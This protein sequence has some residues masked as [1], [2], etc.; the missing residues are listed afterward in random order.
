ME[1]RK[2]RIYSFLAAL[3]ILLCVSTVCFCAEEKEKPD[4]QQRKFE[5]TDEIVERVMQ[6]IEENDPEKAK[7]LEQM[8][9]E[10]PE[11]F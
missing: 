10:E 8:R 5:L 6:R 3:T 9:E 2:K 11:K 7:E 1:S 4:N